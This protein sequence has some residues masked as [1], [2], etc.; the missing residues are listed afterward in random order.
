MGHMGHCGCHQ[1]MF[2][3]QNTVV[4]SA[5]PTR[6]RIRQRDED[7]GHCGRVAP[8]GGFRGVAAQVYQF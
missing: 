3:L 1:L 8:R 7:G 6:V 4:E 5:N 2:W